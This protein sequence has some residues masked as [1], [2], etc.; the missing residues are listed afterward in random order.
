[1]HL[2]SYAAVMHLRKGVSQGSA[3]VEQVAVSLSMYVASRCMQYMRVCLG[4]MKLVL[5]WW[6]DRGSC[7]D[8]NQAYDT[9]LISSEQRTTSVPAVPAGPRNLEQEAPAFDTAKEVE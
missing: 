7:C 8:D 6:G 2:T 5:P 4:K 3:L 9:I 1:M